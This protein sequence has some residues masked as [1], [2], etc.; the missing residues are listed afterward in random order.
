MRP[1]A[2]MTATLTTTAT[3]CLA[4]TAMAGG[5]PI[6]S[7][8]DLWHDDDGGWALADLTAMGPNG[9]TY[10]T[11]RPQAGGGNGTGLLKYATDGT[12]EWSVVREY[13][14][15]ASEGFTDIEITDEGV[16]VL[17]IAAAE[18]NVTE[19]LLVNYTPDGTL[20]WE[21]RT[22]GPRIP[23][24]L[25]PQLAI[26]PNG[27]RVV[28]TDNGEGAGVLARYNSTGELLFSMPLSFTGFGGVSAL[29][30]DGDGNIIL[31]TLNNAATYRVT[32][33]TPGGTQLWT[34]T[35]GGTGLAL[36]EA[37]IAVHPDGDV[38][39][40]G[41]VEELVGELRVVSRVW[42]YS[43]GGLVQWTTDTAQ[44]FAVST[45]ILAGDD[46]EVYIMRSITF[47][48]TEITRID[49]DGQ[50]A[51]T[52][53][54]DGG[55]FDTS[56]L[57]FAFDSTGHLIVG[58]RDADFLDFFGLRVLRYT[59]AG[60]LVWTARVAEEPGFEFLGGDLATGPDG[61]VS[62]VTTRRTEPIFDDAMTVH[63][64]FAPCIGDLD[65]SGGV[66]LTDLLAL[67]AAWGPQDNSPADLNSDGIVDTEDL[68][69]LLATW[70]PCDA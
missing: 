68:L 53:D 46:G 48:G 58:G 34:D 26:A 25:A 41:S 43:P 3:M 2:I 4:T 32:K 45:G 36:S 12:L 35:E 17:G 47:P 70:G 15:D 54:Y 16:S 8:S 21:A 33:F 69:T 7:W 11:T 6:M 63:L 40:T 14:P 44:D 66:G 22:I 27:D 42:R 52:R 1:V 13:V 50:V 24:F 59:T 56:F 49:D 29:E 19:T 23:G 39:V 51:W 60:D 28:A 18:G 55:K 62:I 61:R 5:P 20:L 30:L 38:V 65:A 64:Q 37:F 67:L 9:E 31:V 57:N 10:V